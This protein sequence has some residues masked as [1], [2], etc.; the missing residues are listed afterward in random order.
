MILLKRL[1]P[2]FIPMLS[3]FC[4]AKKSILFINNVRGQIF[5]TEIKIDVI[6]FS[7]KFAPVNF[8]IIY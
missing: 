3:I 2:S 8:G 6:G 7:K 4:D 1:N 5:E